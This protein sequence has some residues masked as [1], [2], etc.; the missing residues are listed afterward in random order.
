[1]SYFQLEDRNSNV[2]Q[3]VL[4]GCTTFLTLSYI[5]FVNPLVLGGAGMDTGAVLV[6]KIGRAHV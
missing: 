5:I 3:E 6:A 1:M 2:R 4:A